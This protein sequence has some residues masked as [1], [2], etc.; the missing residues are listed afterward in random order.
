VLE[1]EGSMSRKTSNP[2]PAPFGKLT[3]RGERKHRRESPKTTRQLVY[4]F[5]RLPESRRRAIMN[6]FQLLTP[7]DHGRSSLERY[8]R[9]FSRA[10]KRG[11]QKALFEK[12]NREV[13]N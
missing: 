12:I 13:R 10:K 3:L 11:V 1:F 2:Q 4:E 9:A 5:F 6:E 7:E 8:G